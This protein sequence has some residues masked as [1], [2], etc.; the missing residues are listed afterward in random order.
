M[1]VQI[2]VGC[3]L[4]YPIKLVFKNPS[5]SY[6]WLLDLVLLC[7]GLIMNMVGC[8]LLYLFTSCFAPNILG[9]LYLKGYGREEKLLNHPQPYM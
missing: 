4:I 7:R 5:L 2:K 1:V 3:L 9:A 6:P 8:L